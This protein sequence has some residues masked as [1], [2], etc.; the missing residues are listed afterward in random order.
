MQA[1]P[2]ASRPTITDPK[3]R[4]L[5]RRCTQCGE[6]LVIDHDRARRDRELCVDCAFDTIAC[7]D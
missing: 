4:S 1:E 6:E 7:T 2:A 3:N 5:D